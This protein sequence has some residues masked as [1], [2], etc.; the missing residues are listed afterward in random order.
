MSDPSGEGVSI[1][2]KGTLSRGEFVKVSAIASVM[3]YF[4]TACGG[5]LPEMAAT[6]F[7][8]GQWT[9]GTVDTTFLQPFIAEGD[10][11]RSPDDEVMLNAK[12]YRDLTYYGNPAVE[13]IR[14]IADPLEREMAAIGWLDVE[15][16][17]RY[18]AVDENGNPIYTCNTYALDLMRLLLGNDVIGS[19]YNTATGELGVRGPND[20]ELPAGYEYLYANNIDDFMNKFGGKYGWKKASSQAQLKKELELGSVCMAASAQD[21][22]EKQ[23][24]LIRDE[25]QKNR[26]DLST[27]KDFVGHSFTLFD[28]K[29]GFLLSQS[30]FNIQDQG[31]PY[32]DTG[33]KDAVKVNPMLYPDYS[34][35]VHALPPAAPMAAVAR[36]IQRA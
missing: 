27:V 16:S 33:S 30:T 34:F 6:P 24:Q 26:Q 4:L 2:K 17:K 20:P 23:R 10:A 8:E 13:K 29:K 9:E 1:P 22:I 35:W 19:S 7:T 32:N 11:L 21:Y 25:A 5:K 14:S 36:P 31:I 18:S 28:A 3:A 15:H 12:P